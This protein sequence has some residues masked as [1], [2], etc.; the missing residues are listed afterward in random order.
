MV[1]NNAVAIVTVYTRINF[2]DAISLAPKIKSNVSSRI[3]CPFLFFTAKNTTIKPISKTSSFQLDFFSLTL[4]F[5][6]IKAIMTVRR[7][8][9]KKSGHDTQKVVVHIKKY[10]QNTANTVRYKF[11]STFFL[12]SSN[13][14]FIFS[15]TLSVSLSFHRLFFSD[16]RMNPR[17]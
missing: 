10:R 3:S 11:S 6:T 16:N 14:S 17:V 5:T 13:F 7:S 8:L 15:L 9:T 4:A 12:F 1:T 2:S